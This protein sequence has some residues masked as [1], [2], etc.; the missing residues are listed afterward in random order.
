MARFLEAGLEAGEIFHDAVVDDGDAAAA[1]GMGVAVVIGRASV[2]GPTGVAQP[3]SP[4]KGGGRYIP[5]EL[6]G[7]RILSEHTSRYVGIG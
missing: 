5:I 6:R 7:G 2:G 1:V 3:H 4:M